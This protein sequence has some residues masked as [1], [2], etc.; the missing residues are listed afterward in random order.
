MPEEDILQIL[1]SY[2]AA[3]WTQYKETC[4]SPYIPQSRSPSLSQTEEA[5]TSDS[6][7]IGP[8]VECIKMSPTVD[9]DKFFMGTHL[10]PALTCYLRLQPSTISHIGQARISAI[11]L[12]V[13]QK[14]LTRK[15]NL[16]HGC[17]WWQ[18]APQQVYQHSSHGRMAQA[19]IIWRAR[20]V[21]RCRWRLCGSYRT[22][23]LRS[24]KHSR[25]ETSSRELRFDTRKKC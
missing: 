2:Q 9:P 15:W 21:G 17:R 7:E 16:V 4:K 11:R 14:P 25:E 10:H 23:F 8:A 3:D 13:A 18:W 12:F 22:A 24:F 1:L 19:V 6:S 5:W 20:T